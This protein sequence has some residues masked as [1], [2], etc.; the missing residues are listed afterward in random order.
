[1]APPSA[2]IATETTSSTR[3]TSKGQPT[4]ISWFRLRTKETY[5]RF[6]PIDTAFQVGALAVSPDGK[7]LAM[8]VGGPGYLAPP[9]VCDL[10]TERLTPLVPDD[11]ARVEWISTFVTAARDLLE[12]VLPAATVDGV[13]V[14]RATLLPIP[15]EFASAPQV[16]SRLRRLGRLARPLCDRPADAAPAPPELQ[17]LLDEARLFF[18]YLREDYHAA[19]DS[20][21]RLE[22]RTSSP[23]ERLRLLSLRAQI[24]LGQGATDRAAETIAFLE[25]VPRVS[26]TRLEI[27]PA[28]PVLTERGRPPP[29]LALLPLLPVG[30][31]DQ[32]RPGGRS[33]PP[34]RRWASAT[35]TPPCPAS[36]STPRMS[37]C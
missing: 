24:F 10:A 2:S 31:L 36:G 9:A 5:K 18:D 26:S 22:A 33:A 25:T 20:L 29:P 4:V 8:R 34:R 7:T 37:R 14:E 13:A 15:G 32:G 3:A 12:T 27:T 1:M 19:L 28:G 6:H 23:D 21:E 35:S 16:G 30:G 11:S 17:A